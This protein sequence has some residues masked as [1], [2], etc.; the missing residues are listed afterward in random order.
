MNVIF[1]IEVNPHC[2]I[3][4]LSDNNDI[5]CGAGQEILRKANLKPYKI[6]SIRVLNKDDFDRL[7]KFCE[8]M[9]E[10]CN[11][12]SDYELNVLF[13]DEYTICVNGIVDTQ[14]CRYWA[15]KNIK[16]YNGSLYP[17]SAKG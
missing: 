7:M 6:I 5:S 17:E 12:N 14:N 16:L 1:G 4:I 13:S 15:I 8:I 3:R 2:S 10:M 11:Q 9:R